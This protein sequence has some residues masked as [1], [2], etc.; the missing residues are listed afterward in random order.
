MK[1]ENKTELAEVIEYEKRLW[2]KRMYPHENLHKV[3]NRTLLY[4]K[5]LRVMEYYG[6][7]SKWIKIWGGYFFWKAIYCFIGAITNVSIPLYVFDR[8]L[9]IMHLQNIVVSAKVKVGENTCLFHN[10]T[11]G[12]KLGHNTNGNCPIIGKGVTICTGACILGDIRIADGIT[13]AANAVVTKS[14]EEN[15]IVIGGIPAKQISKN[16]DWSMLRFVNK[17]DNIENGDRK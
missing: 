16:P 2:I 1:I 5:A 3:K 13:I 14:F 12:I 7:K 17:V 6:T 10:T 11:L 8:G 4:M 15:D 9:L